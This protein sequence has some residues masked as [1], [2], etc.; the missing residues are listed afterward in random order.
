MASL[1]AQQHGA[2]FLVGKPANMTGSVRGFGARCNNVASG[3]RPHS[4]P[5]VS[6]VF[7]RK[8][9]S[10]GRR[11]GRKFEGSLLHHGLQTFG[12]P[13]AKSAV[14]LWRE[15]EKARAAAKRM[16]TFAALSLNGAAFAQLQTAARVSALWDEVESLE[17]AALEAY[18]AE[19]ASASQDE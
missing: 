7:T 16:T 18:E 13:R 4:L 9:G 12:Q 5:H 15:A 19:K 1:V 2:A 8:E 3:S 6:A 10:A 17:E 14:E 11:R